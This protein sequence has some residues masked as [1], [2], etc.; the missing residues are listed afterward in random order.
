MQ[1][2][3]AQTPKRFFQ[4]RFDAAPLYAEAVSRP[5]L[6]MHIMSTLTAAWDVTIGS[7]SLRTPILIAH[8]RY[9]YVVPY[10]LWEGVADKLPM[11]RVEIFMQSGHQPFFEEPD[12]FATAVTD[13]MGGPK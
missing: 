13:W 12:R 2:L 4:A 9:D 6:L 8:G 10:T 1:A 11:A 5:Q 7:S 3:L